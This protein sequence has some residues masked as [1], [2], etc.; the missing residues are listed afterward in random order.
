MAADSETTEDP[1]DEVVLG[2]G[3][4]LADRVEGLDLDELP[5]KETVSTDDLRDELDL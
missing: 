5:D 4:T 3:E 1:S 2:N